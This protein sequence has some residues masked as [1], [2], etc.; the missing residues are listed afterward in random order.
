[1]PKLQG[2]LQL[3]LAASVAVFRRVFP[4]VHMDGPMMP[5]RFEREK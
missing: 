4:H 5:S 1:M 3:L 2:L